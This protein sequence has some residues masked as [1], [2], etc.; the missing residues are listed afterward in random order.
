MNSSNPIQ[1]RRCPQ[2]LFVPTLEDMGY[3]FTVHGFTS[4]S[5]GRLGVPEWHFQSRIDI[6]EGT[7]IWEIF[8]D[9]TEELRAIYRSGKFVII[10]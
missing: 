8:N 1:I 4:G 2:I 3:P 9:G 7:E 10:K 5:N 6:Q